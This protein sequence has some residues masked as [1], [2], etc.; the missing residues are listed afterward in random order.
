M[1][2]YAKWF[3]CSLKVFCYSN[4]SIF[5]PRSTCTMYICS[6][7][8]QQTIICHYSSLSQRWYINLNVK[9]VA[10]FNI[11][12]LH[13][14]FTKIESITTRWRINLSQFNS[15]PSLLAH[16]MQLYLA[17]PFAYT[18]HTIM[19]NEMFEIFYIVPCFIKST[20]PLHCIAIWIAKILFARY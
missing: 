3:K 2:Y 15:V 8:C 20:L 1:K 16:V 17:H 12:F 14:F 5:F 11:F 7:N 18:I 4:P 10:Y 19:W 6:N 9:Q 13:F